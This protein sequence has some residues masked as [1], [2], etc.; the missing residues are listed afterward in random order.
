MNVP[1]VFRKASVILVGAVAYAL[2][3]VV[4]ALAHVTVKPGEVATATY[5]VF[6]VS[7]PNEK[8][9]STTSVKLLIPEDI[10]SVTPTKKPGWNITTEKSGSGDDSRDT[11][12]SWTDGDIADGLR[13]EFTFSAKTPS[14]PTELKW[15]AYQTYADGTVVSWDQEQNGDGHGQG[16]P[17]TG[18]FSVTNVTANPVNSDTNDAADPMVSQRIANAQVSADRA[19]YVGVISITVGLVA[20]FLA[21][22]KK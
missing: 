21:T 9:V 8:D 3:A 18:P 22:R 12:I 10:T 19:L 20:V 13:D 6:T 11:A 14:S 17:N 5:Q 2:V 15:K 4:P 1:A 16:E 7:V